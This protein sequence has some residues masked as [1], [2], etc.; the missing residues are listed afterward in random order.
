MT[1]LVE[2]PLTPTSKTFQVTL[3]GVA[4]A[5]AITWRDPY[6]WFL[7]IATVTGTK[8]VSGIPLVAGIDLLQPYPQY[9]FGGQL[10]VVSDGDPTADPTVDNLGITSHLVFYVP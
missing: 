2:I 4:Y 3:S 7:D 8:M 9:Q 10:I 6:A 5:M 1:T